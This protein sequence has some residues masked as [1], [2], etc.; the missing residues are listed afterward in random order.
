MGVRQNDT[1]GCVSD[2]L[3]QR[4]DGFVGQHVVPV[5]SDVF[6]RIMKKVMA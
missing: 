5:C 4:P 1:R 6:W 3:T 2:L